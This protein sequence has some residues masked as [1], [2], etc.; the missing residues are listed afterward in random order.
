VANFLSGGDRGGLFAAG[1]AVTL[2]GALAKGAAMRGERAVFVAACFGAALFLAA[3]AKAVDP[4]QQQAI[5]AHLDRASQA[6]V[7]PPSGGKPPR[8]NV[9]AA[10]KEIEAV[11]PIDPDNYFAHQLYGYAVYLMGD[12]DF[13][14]GQ[15]TMA[16]RH[17]PQSAEAYLGRAFAEYDACY[18]REALLDETEALKLDRR[19]EAHV[20]P[21][22]KLKQRVLDCRAMIAAE[23]APQPQPDQSAPNWMDSIVQHGIHRTQCSLMKINPN[24]FACWT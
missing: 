13:A 16:I 11:I 20:I 22:D 7:A 19:M 8:K 12:D 4:A 14:I 15:F 23:N 21:L 2:S 18:T 1:R 6:L 3:P 9:E 17:N 24:D 10:I 5:N